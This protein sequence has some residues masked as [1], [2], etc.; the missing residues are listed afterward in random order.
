MS[1]DS[2]PARA[3]LAFAW[4]GAVLFVSSLGYFLYVYLFRL[5][6]E[7]RP[8][9]RVD[10]KTAM[11][12]DLLLFTAFALHHSVLA[13]PGAKRVVAHLVSPTLERAT[14]V[15]IASMLFALTCALWQPVAGELY[16]HRGLAALPHVTIVGG[17]LWLIANAVA[18]LDPLELAGLRPLIGSKQTASTDTGVTSRGPYGWVRHP[19]Y[20]GFI[21]AFWATPTMTIGHLLFAA[22]TTA[23]IIVGALLEEKDLIEIFGDDYRHYRKR[24]SMLIPWRKAA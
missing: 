10:S 2:S 6:G 18:L 23:Y 21:I 16:D 1:T 12:I 8:S 22:V 17:G 13:R 15:W 19:I 5:G 9:L 3:A 14:Y 20:L 11:A 7:E 4:S 24:V